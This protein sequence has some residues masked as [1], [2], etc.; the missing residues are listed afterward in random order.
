M[1]CRIAFLILIPFLIF[2]QERKISVKL[3]F[4]CEDPIGEQLEFALKTKLKESKKYSYFYGDGPADYIMMITCMD[5]FEHFPD[6]SYRGRMC[7]Y[8]YTIIRYESCSQNF[9]YCGGGLGG[10]GLEKVDQQ[11]NFL[12][13]EMDDYIQSDLKKLTEKL[14]EK[15]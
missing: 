3:D 5:P 7:M 4:E 8:S 1:F 14:L 6:L 13:D 12:L 9:T 11:A 10:S 15:Y 2:S